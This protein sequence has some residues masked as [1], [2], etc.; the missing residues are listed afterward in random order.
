MFETRIS[1]FWR[2]KGDNHLKGRMSSRYIKLHD[3]YAS[4]NGV[5]LHH[6]P[7]TLFPLV[8]KTQGSASWTWFPIYLHVVRGGLAVG[9]WLWFWGASQSS[10]SCWPRRCWK[11]HRPPKITRRFLRKPRGALPLRTSA[12]NTPSESFIM[13]NRSKCSIYIYIFSQIYFIYR[14]RDE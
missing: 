9:H 10:G 6:I 2:L 5:R 11:D 13:S 1:C 8:G 7:L 4:S 14:E 12:G 3:G